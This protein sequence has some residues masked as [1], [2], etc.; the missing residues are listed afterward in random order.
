[1]KMRK[2]DREG[3]G[4]V[5]IRRGTTGEGATDKGGGAGAATLEQKL[6]G[7]AHAAVVRSAGERLTP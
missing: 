4:R 3:S 6:V 1:M 2:S 5:T 7:V